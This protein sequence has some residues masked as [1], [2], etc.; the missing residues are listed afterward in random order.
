MQERMNYSAVAPD[1]YKS[2]LAMQK[3]LASSAIDNTL[4]ELIKIRVAQVNGCAYCVHVHTRDARKF[5]EEEDRIYAL[6][7]WRESPLFNES[8]RAALELAETVTL[9]SQ[10]GVPQETWDLARKYFDEQQLADILLAIITINV[11]TRLAIATGM[12]PGQSKP[13]INKPAVRR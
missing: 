7:V 3:Y 5:G 4:H 12:V 2:M 9:I 10:H 11:F 6:S 13:V 1:A 8:E